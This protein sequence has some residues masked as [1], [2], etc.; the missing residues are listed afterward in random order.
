MSFIEWLPLRRFNT[1]IVLLAVSL[2]TRRSDGR[3]TTADLGTVVNSRFMTKITE[4]IRR[5][6]KIPDLPRGFENQRCPWNKHPKLLGQST[7]HGLGT[8]GL[9]LTQS[10]YGLSYYT[11]AGRKIIRI[12]PQL[13]CD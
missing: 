7:A 3:Q 8:T 12:A 1:T 10:R 5:W 13:R 11:C 4:D 6:L 2:H 9:I